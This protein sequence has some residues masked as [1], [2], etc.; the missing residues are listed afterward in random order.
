MVFGGGVTERDFSREPPNSRWGLDRLDQEL[1]PLDKRFKQPCN[2]TGEG[3]DVYIMDTGI[4]YSHEEFDGRA[5]YAGCDPYGELEDDGTE[6]WDC[7]GHGTQVAGIV[8][9]KTVGVAPDVNLYSVRVLSC[10]LMGTMASIVA[11]IECII[12]HH[13]GTGR[14]AV[15]NASVFGKKSRTMKKA[16][17]KALGMGLH[18]VTIAGNGG[19]YRPNS[20]CSI[21]PANVVG[22]LTVG[23]TAI[24]DHVYFQSNIGRC[25]DLFAPGERIT[26]AG[27]R[28][29]YETKSSSGTS[30]AAPYVAGAVALLLQRCPNMTKKAMHR[31]VT[32]ELTTLNNVNFTTFLN[33]PETPVDPAVNTT[34]VGNQH[35]VAKTRN[36]LLHLGGMCATKG[37]SRLKLRIHRRCSA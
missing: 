10:R 26:S 14:P 21:S 8:G 2:L 27:H 25:M 1:L 24:D 7:N 35:L 9:G 33:P 29:D 3:V 11:G 4:R 23:A 28:R 6:G 19:S 15:I 18:F 5:H 36:K 17:K 20:A 16:V 22:A 32:R 30:F 12:N 37:R 34:S 13:N 31:V